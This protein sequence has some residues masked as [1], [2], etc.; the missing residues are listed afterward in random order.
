MKRLFKIAVLIAPLVCTAAVAHAEPFAPKVSPPAGI[1]EIEATVVAGV[2]V[3]DR[4]AVPVP[5]YPGA[6]VVQ[7]EGF[8][9]ME[10]DDKEVKCLCYVKLLTADSIDKVEAFYKAELKS[11]KFKSEFGGAI[12]LFWTGR[13]DLSP[14]EM[15][16]VCQ[17][18]NVLISSTNSEAVMP[19]AK[20]VIAIHYAPR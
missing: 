3:P 19:E 16:R 18:P 17:T 1:N 5:P 4:A 9:T 11:H 6:K 8:Y 15:A 12:R 13:D 14:L 2:K 7:T 20:T 10:E